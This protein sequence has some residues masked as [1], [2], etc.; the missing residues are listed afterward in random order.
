MHPAFEC[1]H[2][3]ADGEVLACVIELSKESPG[4]W[5][6]PHLHLPCFGVAYLSSIVTSNFD[7]NFPSTKSKRP[8]LPK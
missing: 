5:S 3:E 2:G 1:D 8:V 4:S 6:T 7:P